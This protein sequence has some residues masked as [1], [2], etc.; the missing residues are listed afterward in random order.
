MLCHVPNLQG[1][2]CQLFVADESGSMAPAPH[3][4]AGHAISTNEAVMFSQ[5]VPH[6]T[7][8]WTGTRLLLLTF[9][10]GQYKNLQSEDVQ[11]LRQHGFHFDDV[12]YA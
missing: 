9:H 8:P 5:Q 10:T 2:S 4:P 1:V 3:G 12:I 6:A 7:L 11:M